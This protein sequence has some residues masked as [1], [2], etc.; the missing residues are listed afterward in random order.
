M[1]LILGFINRTVSHR[2]RKII[3]FSCST[4][5]RVYIEKSAPFPDVP[6]QL[7][8]KKRIFSNGFL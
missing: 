8:F 4:K 3:F 6:N 7:G 5:F 1:T 2:T